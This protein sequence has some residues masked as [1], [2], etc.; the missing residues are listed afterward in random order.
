MRENIFVGFDANDGTGDTLRVAFT[1]TNNNFSALYSN[2][3]YLTASYTLQLTD[4]NQIM[5]VE[6]GAAGAKIYIPD[7][8]TTPFPDGTIIKIISK[9]SAYGN[10]TVIPNTNT[11]LYKSGNNVSASR[12]VTTYGVAT[13]YSPTSNVWY[14][15][16]DSLV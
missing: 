6:T 9:T 1:K 14:I 10:V 5:Y 11:T 13:L 2:T 7:T 12:N 8:G 4:Q 3:N 16:S 15:Q